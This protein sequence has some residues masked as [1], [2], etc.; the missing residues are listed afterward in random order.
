MEQ[1]RRRDVLALGGLAAAGLA[2]AGC[3]AGAPLPTA[4]HERNP[5][6]AF[7][8]RQRRHSQVNFANWPLYIDTGRK[9]LQEFTAATGITVSYSE[10]IEE[11][12]DWVNKIS[13]ILRSGQSIGYDMM[14]VTNG[15]WFSE[16][17]SMGEL[18]PLDQ[19]M[20]VNFH[21]YAAPRFQHRSF[22]PGNTYSIP[23]ASGTTGIAWNP[24]FIQEPVT[25]I[26]ELWNPAYKGR[27]GMLTDIQ[28]VGN[29]GL[30][31][32]GINPETSTP[33]D[34]QAAAR[35]LTQQRR[36][37]LVRGYYGQSY[38]DELVAGHT[39]ISMAWSGDIFQQ[40]LSSG[41]QLKFVIPDEG[42]TLWTDNMMIPRYAQNPVD[43]MLLM[44]WY[45]QPRIAA[46]LTE[47][48]NYISA[49]PAAQPIIAA[50]AARAARGSRALLHEVAT[51]ELVWPSAADYKRLYNYPDV[52]GKAQA[53]YESIFNPIIA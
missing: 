45:Y 40:N 20:L 31:K 30:L 11:V 17:V 7:W 10:V 4:M 29:F 14:V 50:A 27:V 35:V 28:D 46:Q 5:V 19:S 12:S 48:I 16:L 21:K 26:S 39:W 9:T 53:Q 44:D 3:S 15:F 2:L 25:S 49:V 47:S 18:V 34:W 42:G 24:K 37:G 8:S 6:T 23:W 33:A 38:I 51:S 36:G 41:S 13:P 32:L 43:A 22:D 1:P 52:S